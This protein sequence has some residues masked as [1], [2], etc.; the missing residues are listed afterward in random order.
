MLYQPEGSRREREY[1]VPSHSKY[2]VHMVW[3]MGREN[4]DLSSEMEGR[5]L[6]RMMEFDHCN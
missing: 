1:H 3:V 6:V 4:G 5:L 2:E